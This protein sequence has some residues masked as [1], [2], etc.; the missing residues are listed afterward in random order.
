MTN[1]EKLISYLP[2]IYQKTNNLKL[3]QTIASAFNN[4]DSD[5]ESINKMWLITEATGSYLD[6]LGKNIGIY[7]AYN[8]SDDIFRRRI[9][10]AM[11]NLYFVPIL[12]NF[13]TIIEDIMG[14]SALSVVE[15]WN[16]TENPES[17]RI[18][19]Q[20]VVPAGETQDLLNNLE[21][22]YS[23]GVKLDWSQFQE[24]YAVYE[25]FGDL[26]NTGLADLVKDSERIVIPIVNTAFS[27]YEQTGENNNTGTTEIYTENELRE[28]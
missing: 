22:I 28:V 17:A 23:A 2:S 12:N 21:Y 26:N 24:T 1:Y 3:L 7:R 10:V 13:Y 18:K 16:Y 11:Y 14:Y 25:S 20:V 5:L 15:G 8:Q 4:F 6:V 9:K 27:V 19:A